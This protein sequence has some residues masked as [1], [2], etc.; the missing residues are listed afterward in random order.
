LYRRRSERVCR[1]LCCHGMGGAGDNDVL[2]FSRAMIY[3]NGQAYALS[4]ARRAMEWQRRI[5]RADRVE[6][7]LRV[8]DALERFR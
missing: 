6:W 7:W 1:P 4:I 5:G 3:A 2:R 8:V